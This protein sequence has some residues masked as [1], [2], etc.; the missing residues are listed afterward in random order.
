MIKGKNSKNAQFTY[1][2]KSKQ[3]VEFVC[4][5][6]L[7]YSYKEGIKHVTTFDNRT[8]KEY[9]RYTYRS[10]SNKYFTI[11]YDRWYNN[12]IKHIPND[13]ILNSTICLIWY[14]GDGGLLNLKRSQSIKLSTQCFSKEEQEKIL[15][16]QLSQFDAKL[17]KADISKNDVQQYFIY[18][19]HR[20]IK[21]F[22]EYIGDC[23][24][25]DYMYKWNIKPY[26]NS[27]PKQDYRKYEQ[28]ICKLF[29]N[30]LTYYAV[31]KQLNIEPNIAKYY[32]IKNN[33]YKIGGCNGYE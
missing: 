14:I 33:L 29:K 15:L 4:N 26:K 25:N 27:P 6:F 18:I 13:L 32:L 7:E 11:E 17:M 16:P 24:F 21:E 9:E 5:E 23:P 28:E 30:G 2:S 22:L 8:S 3:H 20:K 1:T 31:A 19:P 12:N 10:I